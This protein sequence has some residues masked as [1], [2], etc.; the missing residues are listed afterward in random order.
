MAFTLKIGGAASRLRIIHVSG[1]IKKCE[2]RARQLLFDW[3]NKTLKWAKFTPDQCD[4]L[5]AAVE[6]SVDTL[7]KL[8][9]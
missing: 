9:F 3:L 4:K 6:G 8:D 7:K 5:K 1:T 2:I